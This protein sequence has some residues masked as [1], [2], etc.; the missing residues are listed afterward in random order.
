MVQ[1]ESLAKLIVIALTENIAGGGVTIP[2]LAFVVLHVRTITSDNIVVSVTHLAWFPALFTKINFK[3][4]A[5][6]LFDFTDEKFISEI[7][8]IFVNFFVCYNPT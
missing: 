6:M 1:W 5:Y 3:S 4:S 2:S 7:I 8:W